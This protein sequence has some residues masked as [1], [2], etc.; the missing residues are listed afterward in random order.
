MAITAILHCHNKRE[1]YPGAGQGEVKFCAAVGDDP[2]IKAHFVFTPHAD[3]ALGTLNPAAYAQLE[4]G[5]NYLVTIS[6]YVS[7]SGD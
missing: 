3:F 5:K 6:E 2:N 7:S 1:S 4:E